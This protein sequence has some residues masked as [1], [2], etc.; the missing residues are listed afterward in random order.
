MGTPDATKQSKGDRAYGHLVGGVGPG[1]IE[2]SEFDG[3]AGMGLARWNRRVSTA[4]RRV[5]RGTD[6]GIVADDADEGFCT[7]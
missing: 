7:V 5:E 1:K 3:A 2:K 6:F 4:F